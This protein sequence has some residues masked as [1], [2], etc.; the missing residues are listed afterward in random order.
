[1][2]MRASVRRRIKHEE[3]FDTHPEISLDF[4]HVRRTLEKG[5]SK[6]FLLVDSSIVRNKIRRFKDAMPR[7]HPHYAVK[8]NPHPKVLK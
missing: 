7:V 5:Y 2:Q 3:I 8:A 6:P 4:E 1:M